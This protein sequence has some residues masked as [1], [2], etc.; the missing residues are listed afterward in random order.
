[1][2]SSDNLE[3]IIVLGH[4]CIRVSAKGFRE[5][6]ELVKQEVSLRLAGQQR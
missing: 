2:A 6:V 3:Q 4:G 5:E 1:M